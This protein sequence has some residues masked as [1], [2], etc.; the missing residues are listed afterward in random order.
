MMSLGLL[1]SS[2]LLENVLGIRW[3]F[4]SPVLPSTH[5]EE[6]PQSKPTTA[7]SLGC[8]VPPKSLAAHAAISNALVKAGLSFSSYS[9]ACQIVPDQKALMQ[10]LTRTGSVKNNTINAFGQTQ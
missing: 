7:A 5:C 3:T 8:M 2:A 1:V 4:P 6:S 9:A 10:L